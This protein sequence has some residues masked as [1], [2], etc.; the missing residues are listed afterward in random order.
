[1]LITLKPHSSFSSYFTETEYTADIHKYID[2]VYYLHS[3]HPAFI[4][5]LRIQKLNGAE[6][7]YVFVD[8]NLNI[9]NVDELMLRRAKEGDVIY[10]VPA[11]VGGGGKRGGILAV[12]AIAA[13]VFLPILGVGA[14]IGAGGAAGG[15]AGAAGA[16]AAGAGGIFGTGA[17][18]G[19]FKNLLAN[20][21]L[22]V[23]SSLFSNK[24]KEEQTRQNDMFGSLTNSTAS[25]VPIALNYGMVR[26]AGQ[27][28]SGYINTTEHGRNVKVDVFGEITSTTDVNFNTPETV[29]QEKVDRILKGFNQYG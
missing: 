8:K 14:G 27:L 1:M 6:E 18:G 21:A 19:F 28:I 3:M 16:G 4:E 13:F 26:V 25:G 17:V 10:I 12:L 23:L 5:Y 15:A 9:I 2:I 24:P 29:Q 20:L 22:S 11:I 7:S